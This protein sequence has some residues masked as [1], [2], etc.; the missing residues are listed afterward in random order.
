MLFDYLDIVYLHLV[1]FINSIKER[2]NNVYKFQLKGNIM[3][4][5]SK[6]DDEEQ[7]R[8]LKS[9]KKIEISR[10]STKGMTEVT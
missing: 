8:Y 4:K 6:E 7:E 3:F 2:S 9:T 1:D 10:I 5:S